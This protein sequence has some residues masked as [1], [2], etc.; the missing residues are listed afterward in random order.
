MLKRKSG[1]SVPM[2]IICAMDG[3]CLLW[4]IF[5]DDDND[6]DDEG[7]RS[8]AREERS[9]VSRKAGMTTERQQRSAL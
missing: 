5:D 6:D 1:S 8:V 4:A 2:A 9:M 7:R 3:S